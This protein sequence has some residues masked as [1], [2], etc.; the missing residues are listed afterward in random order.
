MNF[1]YIFKSAALA[2]AGLA[3]VGLN[4][5]NYL[6]VVPPEQP[7]LDDAM[8]TYDRAR[9]YLY[10][11]YKGTADIDA[12]V[13]YLGETNA[14]TDEYFHPYTW[15]N[16]NAVLKGVLVNTMSATTNISWIWGQTYRYIGQ[17]LLF[18]K[19]LE[20]VG[21]V[22]GVATEEEMAG[23]LAETR[24]LKAYYHFMTLRKYGPIPITKEL[25]PMDASSSAF[26]GR[27]HFDYCVAYIC[28]ELDE[29]AK[30]LPADRPNNEKG[31]ATS[32]ICKAIKA[33]L[34]LYAA[35]PLWNGEFYAKSWRNKVRTETDQNVIN[36]WTGV[37]YGE[38][39][40][41]YGYELFQL[42]FDR[43]RWQV[44][45]DANL[46]ALA[47]AEGEGNRELYRDIDKYKTQGVPLTFIPEDPSIDTLPGHAAR[48][49]DIAEHVML[50]KNLSVTREDEGNREVI[51][52]SSHG[53]PLGSLYAR[54]PH[55]VV[56][57]SNGT[58]PEAWS[59]TAPS[60][61]S[62]WHFLTADGM[63]P[64]NDPNFYDES[65]WYKTLGLKTTRARVIKLHANR[66]PRFYAWIG[67]DGGDYG[68]MFYEN[69][70]ALVLNMTSSSAQGYAPN[71]YNRDFSP[72]GYLCQKYIHPQAYFTSAGQQN[73]Y[74]TAP[75]NLC[76]LAELYLNIAECYAELGNDEKA[77]EY[78][79][80]IRERAGVPG[81]TAAMAAQSGMS[82]RDWVRNE[83]FVEL[84]NEG[85][86][87]YDIRRWKLG[88]E[89]L[90][91]G[92]RHVL[93]GANMENPSV[94]DFNVPVLLDFPYSW[95]DRQYLAPVFYNEVSKNPQMVQAPGF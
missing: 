90:G 54:W 17:C 27:S 18:E 42:N 26:P 4:S 77:L 55:K 60:L 51:F 10:S 91:F 74:N 37:T 31:R 76:R 39:P 28:H 84:Y 48:M 92:T 41:D 23:W 46:E 66:E 33:R 87:Y 78:M 24:F 32:T 21:R 83:R 49:L 59:G 94:T 81:L 62:V 6:D 12:P 64:E 95:A 72:S 38:Q 1:K 71:D 53:I 67:F 79:N 50:M 22:Y 47:L 93:Q 8:K 82:V 73:Q 29:A 69:K 9:G 14:T 70:R 19:K 63:L 15:C 3:M 89:R 68:N 52:S 88:N 13:D 75:A 61:Y 35:S 30:G 16:D 56:K 80:V 11:C 2:L 25:I 65:E 86:R 44:A 34:L 20:E 40:V 36:P 5:C 7:N 45:L 58:Y 57:L 43:N 85:V